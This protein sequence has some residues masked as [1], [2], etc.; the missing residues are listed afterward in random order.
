MFSV[1][2]SLSYF[3]TNLGW[4]HEHLLADLISPIKVGVSCRGWGLRITVKMRVNER[5]SD[6]WFMSRLSMID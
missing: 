6:S 3:C 1:S 5:G 4:E 2:G